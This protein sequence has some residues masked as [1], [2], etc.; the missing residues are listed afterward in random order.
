[1]TDGASTPSSEVRRAIS[2]EFDR[3]HWVELESDRLLAT[4]GIGPFA[5]VEQD[6]LSRA[7]VIFA[8][9]DPA[10]GFVSVEL[11]DHE[12]HIAQL[13]VL[14]EHGRHGIG[15]S[16]LDEAILWAQGQ[17]LTGVTL[18]TFRDVPWNAPFYLRVGFVEV[19][20]PAPGLATIRRDERERGLDAMGLRLAMRLTL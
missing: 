8:A 17:G 19:V 3:L 10:V 6:G 14:P 18:T 11:V 13:S 12:A 16:L 7:A 20:N 9:G 4:V 15:R 5:G 1:V 2:D